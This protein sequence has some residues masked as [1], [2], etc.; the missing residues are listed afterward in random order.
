MVLAMLVFWFTK[1]AHENGFKFIAVSDSKGNIIN[2]DGLDPARVIKHIL[3]GPK[4]E[5]VI[6]LE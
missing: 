5:W 3:M 6:L 2:P 4:T 1:L